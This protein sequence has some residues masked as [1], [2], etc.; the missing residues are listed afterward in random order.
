MTKQ[1][2][3]EAMQ[4]SRRSLLFGSAGV[5]LSA[6]ALPNVAVAGVV[7]SP[8]VGADLR[9]FEAE[10]PQ[11]ALDDLHRRLVATRWPEGETVADRSQ[12]V[13]PEKLRALV[14][15][16]QSGYDWRK[17]E[18][19]LNAYPQ[20]LTEIDGVAIHF[21]HIRSKNE[22]ALPL[23]M[24]HGWPGSV[25][26]LLNV[27]GPLTDPVAHGGNAEDAF[28]LVIPSIPGFGFSGKP[29]EKGWDPQRI[30]AAWDMLMKRLGYHSYVSQGGDW[31]AIISD[32]LGRQAPEGLLGIHVNRVERAT[33]FPP[34]VAKALMSG[35]AAP[36]TLS[37]DEKAIFNEARD[38]LSNGFGY[39]AIMSTR[40]ETVGYGLADSPVGLGAWLYDKIADWVFMRGDPESALGR[41]AILDNITLYWLTN[42]GPSSGK[43]YWENAA[44]MAK[45]SPIKVPVAV[46]IFPGEVYR[47]PKKWLSTAYPDLVYYNQVEKG[48]HFAAWEE[49]E[50]FSQEVRAAF[51]GLRS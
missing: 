29:K 18:A 27:I 22:G 44:A 1:Q 10:V 15:Y 48:G 31:G 47:P 4:L 14:E 12:G 3:M 26:E 37:P 32:A 35:D 38:F 39:A 28:H 17:A 30:A 51:R 8:A 33:T 23:I 34:E 9:P 45:L 20:F 13:Q 46:T 21:L 6:V 24:T 19:K 42:T 16:W 5:A 2:S 11:A 36:Q 7:A 43:I 49:P 50:L 40:P 25:F 41:E